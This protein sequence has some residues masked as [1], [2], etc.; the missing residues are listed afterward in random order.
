MNWRELH[1]L[2]PL[3]RLEWFCLGMAFGGSLMLFLAREF[4]GLR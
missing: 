4:G 1:R 2:W 3:S